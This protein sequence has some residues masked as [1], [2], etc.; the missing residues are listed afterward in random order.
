MHELALPAPG[1]ALNYMHTFIR[2]VGGG[3]GGL[4]DVVD[5]EVTA[6][7]VLELLLLFLTR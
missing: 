1:A 2:L 4:V 3:G 7:L 5:V 6:I